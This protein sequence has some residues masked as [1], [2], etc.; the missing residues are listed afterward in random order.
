[1]TAITQGQ[2]AFNTSKAFDPWLFLAIFRSSCL[3]FLAAMS[4]SN[5][6]TQTRLNRLSMIF[7]DPNAQT[8]GNS[9]LAVCD[10]QLILRFVFTGQG[11]SGC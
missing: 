6:V 4:Q 11:L 7:S 1:M 5:V 2:E 10:V 8:D 3:N 9:P